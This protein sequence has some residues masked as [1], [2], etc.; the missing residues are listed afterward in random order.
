MF[1]NCEITG[2]YRDKDKMERVFHSTFKRLHDAGNEFPNTLIPSLHGALI[3]HHL[4]QV[5]SNNPFYIQY[6]NA[7]KENFN[8]DLKKE[9]GKSVFP[10]GTFTLAKSNV[11]VT[12]NV[13]DQ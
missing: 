9:E 5:R 1:V 6:Q 10:R 7:S 11:T 3:E 4:V 8:I 12:R 13:L 2:K